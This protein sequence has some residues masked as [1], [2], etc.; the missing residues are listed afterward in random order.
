MNDQFSSITEKIR[1]L[2]TSIV[3]LLETT[4][5][6]G[7]PADSLRENKSLIVEEYQK[8]LN[9]GAKQLFKDDFVGSERVMRAVEDAY[10]A[11]HAIDASFRETLS[12]AYDG[13][14]SRQNLLID[15]VHAEL[16]QRIGDPTAALYTRLYTLC[17]DHLASRPWDAHLSASV[18]HADADALNKSLHSLVHGDHLDVEDALSALTGSLRYAFADYIE[19]REEPL[20]LL[21]ESLW[22]R[23]EIVLINDYWQYHPH[24]RLLDLLRRK[25]R[26]QHLGAFAKVQELFS[27]H[28]SR[29]D[30]GAA[31]RIVKEV[32][33]TR[34]EEKDTYLRCLMLHPNHDVR[35]YA[36]SNVNLDGFWK[37]VTPEAVPLMTV[38]SM[39]EKVAG[40]KQYDES[41][42]KVFFHTVHRRLLSASS[43]PEVLYASGIVRILTQLP[44]FMEDDYF[45]KLM[46]AVD[47]LTA[48][49][50][51]YG[52]KTG[53]LSRVRREAPQGER[54]D[55]H[56]ARPIRRTSQTFPLSFCESSPATGTSG[57]SSQRIPCSRSHARPS[58]TSTA[59]TGRSAWPTTTSSIRM[60]SARSDET[61][62]SSRLARPSSRSSA[63]P[64]HRRR[65]RSTTF[66]T[67]AGRTRINSCADPRSI[68]SCA[69]VFSN[70]RARRISRNLLRAAAS[71]DTLHTRVVSRDAC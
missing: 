30:D 31:E 9:E 35:R 2:K 68:R 32:Q 47:Y 18:K 27:E 28:N 71:W 67:S 40:S 61:G 53:V 54:Q 17:A 64:A 12:L 46:Q 4:R 59:R 41:F 6:D 65:C 69:G 38:L 49:G 62:V 8:L 63:I 5:D 55:R 44:F 19:R 58:L 70:A 37:V 29:A 11:W 13:K 45:E 26:Q 25:G 10:A 43:R 3:S 50:Q 52:I 20:E 23:P 15:D 34:P 60:C 57:T 66:R 42:Q 36:V 56:A 7:V 16:R 14:I 51:Q 21:E 48:K 39:L 22:M 1:A 33:K 24:V